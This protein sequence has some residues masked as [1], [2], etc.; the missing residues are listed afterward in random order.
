MSHIVPMLLQSML[1][2][3]EQKMQTELPAS[4][5]V[6]IIKIG[7]FQDNPAKVSTYITLS[8]GDPDDPSF[9]DGIV[10]LEDM[11]NIGINF[12]AR[13]IG[14]GELWWRRFTANVGCYWIE[15]KLDEEEALE[16]SYLI[17][18]RLCD[19]IPL[20]NISGLSDQFGEIAV[21]PF[22]YA[23]TNFEGGGAEKYN[24]RGKAKWQVLTERP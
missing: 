1:I 21:Q 19:A 8:P 3:L 23:T 15:E 6:G 11:K 7:R 13:E 2:H 9:Q 20:L 12:P 24:W 22:L 5:R 14:G 10:S 18:G 4:E 17:M 16:Q